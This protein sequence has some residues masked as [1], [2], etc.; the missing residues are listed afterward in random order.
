MTR[1]SLEKAGWLALAWRAIRCHG[2]AYCARELASE[3][4]FDL[5]RGTST[6][7][8]SSF[9][10]SGVAAQ[11]AVDGVRY[12]GVSPQ[13]TRQLL[14]LIPSAAR[15]AVF[16][17]YGC[18]KGRAIIIAA[19]SGFSHLIGVEC[20]HQLAVACRRNLKRS[21]ATNAAV[22]CCVHEGNAA[23]FQPPPRPLVAFLYNPFRGETLRRVI[24]RLR[25]HA[26]LGGHSVWVAYVNPVE[27]E[28]FVEAGFRLH[29]ELRRRGTVLAVAMHFDGEGRALRPGPLP[30]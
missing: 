16:I 10:A 23:E 17:D 25:G 7:S 13:T 18:G 11:A 9:D 21:S 3:V 14:D 19:E 4:W 26:L 15:R 12:Q 27:R 24:D 8:P 20:N 29:G 2:A 6:T 5:V 30:C 22:L 1:V 28:S